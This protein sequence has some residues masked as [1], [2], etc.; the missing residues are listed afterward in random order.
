MAPN[1]SPDHRRLTRRIERA[2]RARDAAE[3]EWR[4]ALAA[5]HQGGMSTRRIGA[6]VGLS[7]TQVQ[8]IIRGEQ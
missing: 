6:V 7:H 4:Q 3:Q 5:A 1:D 8:N 2:Q